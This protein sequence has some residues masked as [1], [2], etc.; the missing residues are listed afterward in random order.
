MASYSIALYCAVDTRCSLL[1]Q[2]LFPQLKFSRSASTGDELFSQ[3]HFDR[4]LIP[5]WGGAKAERALGFAR[6]A[7]SANARLDIE[8]TVE[9]TARSGGYFQPDRNRREP[10]EHGC[11]WHLD[12]RDQHAGLVEELAGRF[13][14]LGLNVHVYRFVTIRVY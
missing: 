9:A 14:A 7:E 10:P 11:W 6:G 8:A 12:R 1:F 4:N 3:F 5:V 2:K 13:K